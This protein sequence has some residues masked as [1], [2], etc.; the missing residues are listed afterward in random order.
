MSFQLDI[1]SYPLAE[2]IEEMGV[3]GCLQARKAGLILR[4]IHPPISLSII[5]PMVPSKQ[6]VLRI[7]ALQSATEF[8]ICTHVR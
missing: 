8:L 4:T 3:H 6:A 5:F 1:G 2:P 7:L